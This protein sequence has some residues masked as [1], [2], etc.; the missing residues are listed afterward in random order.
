MG[1]FVRGAM[2][3]V[4]ATALLPAWAAAQQGATISG[5]VVSEAGAPLSSAS[6]FIENMNIGSLTDAD[7]KYTF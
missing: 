1:R 7:G 3:I 5:R 2:A 6:V 4:A